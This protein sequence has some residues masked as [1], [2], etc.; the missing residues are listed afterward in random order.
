MNVTQAEA[1]LLFALEAALPFVAGCVGDRSCSSSGGPVAISEI[2]KKYDWDKER[3]RWVPGLSPIATKNPK[4][5]IKDVISDCGPL[6]KK[7]KRENDS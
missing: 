6:R 1:Q 5:P 7:G 2:L 3:W 4:Y